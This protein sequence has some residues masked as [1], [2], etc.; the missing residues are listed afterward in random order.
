MA[1]QSTL[2][3]EG[4]RYPRILEVS[5]S[6]STEKDETGKPSDRP[7]CGLIKITREA[8]KNTDL[9]RWGT[10]SSK[11]N[12]KSGKVTFMD[13]QEKEELVALEFKNGFITYYEFHCPH[14]KNNS[15]DQIYEYCEISAEELTLG[16][17]S[18]NQNW[19]SDLTD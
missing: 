5:F 10:D 15:G 13:P 11:K 1:H 12:F 2:H 9:F 18:V 14:N 3:V 7:R 6:I 19:G 4:T 17:D 16:S 8:T